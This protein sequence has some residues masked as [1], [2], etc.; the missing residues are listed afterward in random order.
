MNTAKYHF[1]IEQFQ[2]TVI[3]D[4]QTQFPAHPLYAVNAQAEEVMQTLEYHFLDNVNYTLQC[5]IFFIDNGKDK[6]LIDTGAGISLGNELG[7]LLENLTKAGINPTEITAILISHCHLDHISGLVSDEG[8][9][10]FP[11]AKI[12]INETEWDFWRKENIDLSSMPIEDGFKQ[13][14]IGAVRTNLNPIQQNISTF[15]FG[16]EILNG[17]L[18]VNAI[19]HSPGHTAFLISS[20]NESLLHTGDIFHHPAF[21]LKHPNWATAFD[22]D[23]KQAYETRLKILDQASFDKSFL[24]SYHMP[25]P[26]LRHIRKSDNHYEWVNLNWKF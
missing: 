22:Q 20:N 2:V 15:K 24:T 16:Q 5:N 7:K 6:I 21:D 10:N 4:G 1:S 11:N 9:P 17:I 3:S 18:T 26:A 19:G 8:K 23:A 12:F 14:F 13:N 25:F